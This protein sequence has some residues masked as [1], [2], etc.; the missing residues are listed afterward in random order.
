MLGFFCLPACRA[1]EVKEEEDVDDGEA[2]FKSPD[3]I[4]QELVTL[5]SFARSRWENLSKLELIRQRNKPQ[6]G[7]KAP[8]RAPF[9]LE[10]KRGVCVSC[11]YLSVCLCACVHVYAH[12]HT[13]TLS[14]SPALQHH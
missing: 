4:S 2:G 7:P 12:T 8:P 9:F 11:A 5:S 1:F 10:T 13:H 3:Q 6:E 14:L